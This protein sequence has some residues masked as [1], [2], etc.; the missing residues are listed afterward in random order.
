[1]VWQCYGC[2]SSYCNDMG[3]GVPDVVCA[4]MVV[5]TYACMIGG[6]PDGM[7]GGMADVM[8]DDITDGCVRV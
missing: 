3:D 7:Y 4:V 2:Y 6:M 8:C 5:S 1:M